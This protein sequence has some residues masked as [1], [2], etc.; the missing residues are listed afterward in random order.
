MRYPV[1]LTILILSL[2]VSCKKDKYASTPSLTLKS[3]SGSAIPVGGTIEMILHV[4]DA[5]GDISN[6]LYITE[7]L[8][9]CS[10][11]GGFDTASYPIPSVPK[12]NN[13]SADIIVTLG[14]Q[15]DPST[16]GIPPL[17]LCNTQ[18]NDTAIFKFVMKDI[19]GHVSDTIQTGK[20]AI[21][22]P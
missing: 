1:L 12:K 16:T 20:I 17:Q 21:I 18:K 19:A 9:N 3:V 14:N 22:Q 6:T 5:E 2:I 13:L 15:T 4:T 7:K 10:S 8:L 11:P